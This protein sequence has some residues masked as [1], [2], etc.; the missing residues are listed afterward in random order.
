MNLYWVLYALNWI[1]HALNGTHFYGLH[2][3]K[4][5]K[6]SSVIALDWIFFFDAHIY[7]QFLG[8]KF[9]ILGYDCH[10]MNWFMEEGIYQ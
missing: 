1:L 5:R 9:L 6:T 8:V 2:Q 3:Q 7:I 4:V 10:N